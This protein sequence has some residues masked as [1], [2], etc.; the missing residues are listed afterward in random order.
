M[1]SKATIDPCT[2][3]DDELALEGGAMPCEH[4]EAT[5][6]LAFGRLTPEAARVAEAHLVACEVCQAEH[7]MFLAE[8]E[9]FERR[10]LAQTRP[11]PAEVAVVEAALGEADA[12][13]SFGSVARVVFAVAA[14]VAVFLG[15]SWLGRDHGGQRSHAT[16]Q[17][18]LHSG[19]PSA[20]FVP[21][22]DHALACALP[23][24]GSYS[25]RRGVSS[26]GDSSLVSGTGPDL[27][28]SESELAGVSSYSGWSRR[29]SSPT[30]EDGVTSSTVT[31]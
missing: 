14:S 5:E 26:S 27:F 21:S 28:C 3:P 4:L 29:A 12:S 25:H 24:S 15:G 20:D 7:E 19:E 8:R 22:E 2:P 30:C 16:L 1:M 13:S 10:A 31:P 11:L 9:L 17:A 6:D 18:S 23:M